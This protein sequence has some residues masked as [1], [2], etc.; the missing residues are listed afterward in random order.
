MVVVSAVWWWTCQPAW[1]GVPACVVSTVWYGLV[2]DMPACVV[3]AVQCGVVVDMPVCVGLEISTI[4]Y[5]HRGDNNPLINSM[6]ISVNIKLQ[7]IGRDPVGKEEQHRFARLPIRGLQ[8]S[9]GS[10]CSS[11]SRRGGQVQE[12]HN[13]IKKETFLPIYVH[14]SLELEKN[15]NT[16]EW[17]R[18]LYFC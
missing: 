11:W 9:Q 1:C 16:N 17:R 15:I 7:T 2:V 14:C 10:S 3:S 13:K 18:R 5:H 6:W 8:P 4:V 12:G